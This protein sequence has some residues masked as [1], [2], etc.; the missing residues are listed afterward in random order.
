MI[1]LAQ[2]RIY[3]IKGLPPLSCEQVEISGIGV[4]SGDR[5]FALQ[6][7]A[8]RLMNGKR[9]ARIHRLRA[10]YASD[11]STVDLATDKRPENLIRFE[12]RT[13][14]PDLEAWFSEFFGQQVRLIENTQSGF[15]DDLEAWGPTVLSQASL[16]TVATWF[17]GLSCEELLLRFRPNL[18]L[19][20]PEAFWEERLYGRPGQAI[21]FRLG[22]VN[23][24][25]INPCQ[26]CVVPGRDPHTGEAYPEFSQRFQ[27][28]RRASLPAWAEPSRF[29]HFYRLA[30][31]TRI[32][33]SQCGS[34][35]Q[36]GNALALGNDF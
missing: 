11:L 15:P 17:T 4:L 13:G 9:E 6:D 2:I 29:D 28:Q 18:L 14:S 21:P 25:G 3:P 24:L 8:G 16:Q 23:L 27:V 32:A 33:P 30:V 35:L 26:R 10:R 20:T 22:T 12:L 19:D 34:S 31:N 1:S 36:V 7:A 5:R